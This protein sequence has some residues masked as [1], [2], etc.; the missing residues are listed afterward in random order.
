MTDGNL[1]QQLSDDRDH[2]DEVSPLRVV[3]GYALAA[4]PAQRLPW[5]LLDACHPMTRDRLERAGQ[6]V[7]Y[8]LG[9]TV[10]AAGQPATDVVILLEGVV[11]VFHAQDK[12][13]QFTVKL[14][15]GPDAVGMI[16]AMRNT[17]Y[18]ASVEA[19]SPVTAVR[20]P[21]VALRE[22]AASDNDFA[23][24]LLTDVTAKFEG[25]MRM[26][27]SMGFDN[28]DTR[29]VRA[30]IEYANYFGRPDPQGTVIRHPLSR[31]RLAREIGTARRSVDR[32]LEHLGQE[33]LVTLS[34][35]GWLIVRDME[36][37]KAKL[38]N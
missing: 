35:K 16:E 27:R 28:C 24:A 19:V 20:I 10:I 21:A 15:R 34:P 32:A 30:L 33:N 4:Q 23:M 31:T 17:S 36:A 7:H 12:D 2:S 6:P 8:E 3:P 26:T 11:R 38:Q 14:L 25:T 5:T 29:L 37:L 1:A 22:A 18:V 13:E 9:E